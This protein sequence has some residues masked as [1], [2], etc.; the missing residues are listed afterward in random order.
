MRE[1]KMQ[2]FLQFE[3]VEPKKRN[4][5]ERIRDFSEINVRY[6]TEEAVPQA[7]RCVQCGD[8][9]CLNKCPLN[10]FIPFWLKRVAEKDLELAFKISNESSPFPEVMG[11]VCPQE[12]L[13]EGDCTL[14]DGYGAISIGAIEAYISETGFEKGFKPFFPGITTEKKVA[15]I[16][17][18]PA[19]LSC[20]NF[21][22]RAGIAVD[23]YEREDKTGGL[24]T[25][26]IPGFK[27]DKSIME[28]RVSL[29]EEAGL[30]VFTNTEVGK[31]I[32]FEEIL[33]KY[34]SVFLGIGA[35]QGREARIMNED[36]AGCY[37]AMEFLTAIQKKNFGLT[38]EEDINLKDK[39]VVVIGGGDTAMDCVRTAIRE[40]AR[41][42]KVLYRRD[43]DN[44]PGSRKEYYNAQE[45]GAE[46]L[47]QTAPKE[48][49]VDRQGN[50]TGINI[51][52]TE[53]LA[54]G[55]DGRQ[56]C[57][58]IEGSEFHLET[59]V[60]IFALGFSPEQPE[61]LAKNAVEVNDWGGIV[62]DEKFRTSN[63]KVYAGGDC[64]RGANLV[65]W[66]ARDGR[67]AAEAIIEDLLG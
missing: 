24:L 53:M 10:N 11:K 62:I 29:M 47:F 5:L 66:A 1:I 35:T 58:I 18:G 49:L 26:G 61:Y 7:D 43:A 4:S 20:A 2:N 57:Q 52:Q 3:R 25:Y 51:Y 56:K 31:D 19:G 30:K 14:N 41:E 27:L 37:Q 67:D 59:E 63:A 16:G 8:P 44:M 12:R 22:L 54:A 39:R 65:V 28:R 40:G 42:A 60:V 13:C 33:E 9:Y 21:L 48:V 38:L 45:E 17:S 50:V 32:S 34:D 15:I 6:S 36:M 23:V 46:F 55:E 64:Y